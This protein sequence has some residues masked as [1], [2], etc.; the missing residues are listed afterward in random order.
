VS[1]VVLCVD[2]QRQHGIFDNGEKPWRLSAV[3]END[4][5]PT[6]KRRSSFLFSSSGEDSRQHVI[7]DKSKIIKITTHLAVAT[8]TDVRLSTT[9]AFRHSDVILTFTAGI[10]HSS[11]DVHRFDLVHFATCS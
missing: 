2:D 10:V 7:D 9:C 6:K 3:R 4:C 11:P 5:S 1:P 8:T